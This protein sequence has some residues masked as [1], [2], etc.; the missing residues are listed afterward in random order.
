VQHERE[1]L[2]RAERLEDHKQREPDR[3]GQ[4]RLVLRVR[5]VGAVD[6]RIG[7]AHPNRLLAP[8]VARAQHV[9][10]DAR[11][12]RRQPSI[13]VLDLARVDAAEP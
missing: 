10:R 1:P 11:D 5:P 3:V 6:D 8:Q 4:Q 2:G 7:H 9:Q 12:D 13:Q